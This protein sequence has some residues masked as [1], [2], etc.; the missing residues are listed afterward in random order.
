ML[1]DPN[2]APQPHLGDLFRED[3]ERWRLRGDPYLWSKMEAQ[4]RQTTMPNSEE[5]LLHLLTTAF[6]AHT[7][8]SLDHPG[9]V[10]VDCLD[11]GGLSRG[12][13][14]PSFWR[15]V[16]FPTLAAR[17]HDGTSR[18]L[19][20]EPETDPFA[21]QF[22]YEDFINAQ[23][24]YR[25]SRRRLRIRHRLLW[26]FPMLGLVGLILFALNIGEV[27]SGSTAFLLAAILLASLLLLTIPIKVRLQLRRSWRH[28][29]GG[30]NAV[31]THLWLGRTSLYMRAADGSDHRYSWSDIKGIE[32]DEHMAL[33]FTSSSIPL[34][35]PKR[36]LPPEV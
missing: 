3:P 10:Y 7:G 16:A 35:I 25:R 22:T 33:L 6:T 18:P 15:E 34:P 30:S 31:P 28:L 36:A 32:Q 2:S 11:H 4:F 20:G 23:R 9:N 24:L 26:F 27:Q 14:A 8:V 29:S 19:A 21:F 17:F 13:V 1:S 12:M 5:E